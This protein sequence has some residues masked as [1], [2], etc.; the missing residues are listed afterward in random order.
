MGILA[1]RQKQAKKNAG[2]L[3]QQIHER[4]DQKNDD[5]LSRVLI[6]NIQ[7]LDHMIEVKEK[8]CVNMAQTLYPDWAIP[9]VL[10]AIGEVYHGDHRNLSYLGPAMKR[11]V[12]FLWQNATVAHGVHKSLKNLVDLICECAI[13]QAMYGA[14]MMFVAIPG[15]Y[16][17]YR[18][19][20]LI[21]P[22]EYRHELIK[23]RMMIG[24][25][26]SRFRVAEDNNR[27]TLEH[28]DEF[29]SALERVLS[30]CPP[31]EIDIFKGTFYEKIP[32]VKHHDCALFWKEVYFRFF[33]LRF[34]MMSAKEWHDVIL[35]HEF[36]V[37]LPAAFFAQHI[38]ENSFWSNKPKDEEH[39][40][41]ERW[42]S[43]Q[44]PE[45]YDNLLVDRPIVRISHTGD[46]ATSPALI[47]DS[48]NEYIE[49]Q[50]MGYHSR[51]PYLKL[52]DSIFRDAFS[53]KFEDDCIQLFRD[54]GY[55]AG[56]I[57]E[58]GVWKHQYENEN[59]RLSDEQLYGEV[60]V[61]AY[62]PKTHKAFLVEC[63][64][65]LDLM[66]SRL[67]KNILSKLRD[68]SEGFRMKLRKK[69]EWISKAFAHHKGIA[70]ELEKVIVT[71]IPIPIMDEKET[72]IPVLD[73]DSL[74]YGVNP[75]DVS[76][77]V[78]QIEQIEII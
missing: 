26:G 66:D 39:K 3:L 40:E 48:M 43:K 38:V 56:H 57:L 65:L 63:K 17:A 34:A 5:P 27:L 11:S 54:N 15:F 31:H 23:Y 75:Y 69:A 42:F 29:R 45:R 10:Q 70:L 60:D 73:Y 46:F 55:L 58:S 18:S 35:F 77:L 61:F 51:H 8:V 76:A 12:A 71:D 50:L 33:S 4:V 52:P 19:G 41:N 74:K 25:P 21:V 20:Q 7:M 72:D 6:D 1:K 9:M 24:A 62:N 67:Y 37:P 36:A 59:L 16:I 53:E 30:G 64:V 47:G 49:K 14:R 28:P 22:P 13:I 32:G 68:D 78:E 44:E 2:E